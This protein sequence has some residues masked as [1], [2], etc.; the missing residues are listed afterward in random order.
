VAPKKKAS[1][2]KPN[3][4]PIDGYRTNLKPDGTVVLRLYR[5]LKGNPR[6]EERLEVQYLRE[7][8]GD[9]NSA[10]IAI[11]EVRY[12]TPHGATP[13][14]IRRFGWQRWLPITH[15]AASWHAIGEDAGLAM[16]RAGTRALRAE[17]VPRAARP[18]RHG[19]P[20]EFYKRIADRYLALRA[21]GVYNARAQIAKETNSSPDTVAKWIK[22]GREL[23]F[24]PP[25][26]TRPT[27]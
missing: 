1:G 11:S 17:G 12:I 13:S 21:K 20:R 19:H 25:H 5:T 8:P 9:P 6:R 7:T 18:G 27:T 26:A 16:T 3:A 15:A 24:I 14:D 2:S 23:G 22:R 10:P 4:S